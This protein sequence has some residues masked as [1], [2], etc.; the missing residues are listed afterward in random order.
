MIAVTATALRKNLFEYLDRAALGETIIVKRNNIEVARIVGKAPADW[1]TAL[2]DDFEL[3]VDADT[4]LQPL[5]DI[6]EAY[7]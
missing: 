5:E 1:R 4:L 6:W 2:D 3:L 7:T